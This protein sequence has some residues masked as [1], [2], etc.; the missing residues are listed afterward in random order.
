LRLL[1]RWTAGSCRM[2][3]GTKDRGKFTADDRLAILP[4]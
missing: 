4:P 2:Y 1:K 3:Y